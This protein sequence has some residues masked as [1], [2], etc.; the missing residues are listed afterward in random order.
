MAAKITGVSLTAISCFIYCSIEVI[1]YASTVSQKRQIADT[2][3]TIL[4]KF[5]L[6]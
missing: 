3:F 2:I 1:D 6:K 4:S 5:C